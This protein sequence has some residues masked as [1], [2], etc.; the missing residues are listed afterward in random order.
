MKITRRQLRRIIKEAIDPNADQEEAAY[1]IIYA[2]AY[3]S[4]FTEICNLA[5]YDPKIH[6]LKMWQPSIK[7]EDA[8]DNLEAILAA[9]IRD[10]KRGNSMG[11]THA[12][13]LYTS[14]AAD[15]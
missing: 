4:K 15:E 11:D 3:V 13:L 10:L 8:L 12:C 2:E 14:D 6:S 5:L 1:A 9:G 7:V